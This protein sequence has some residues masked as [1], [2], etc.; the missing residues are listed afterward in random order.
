MRRLIVIL[1]VCWLPVLGI[2]ERAVAGTLVRFQTN[3]GNFDVELYDTAMPQTVAN[4]LQYV[5]AG[6]YAS[7]IIHR[8][9]TYNPGTIQVVQ[10]GGFELEGGTLLPVPQFSP[11][12]LET[13][14]LN[15][16]GTIAMARGNEPDTATSQIFF[17]I[18]NNAPLDGS[19]AVFGEILGPGGLA[20]LDAMG[21][22]PVYDASA[23][24]GPV[25]TELPLL[26]P[27]LDPS[28]LILVQNV[29]VVPEPVSSLL[30][31]AGMLMLVLVCWKRQPLRGG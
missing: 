24:L 19:Y 1:L 15:L 4:F 6:R 10:G 5:N 12:N 14:P 25:F 7:T 21:T 16:R 22:T 17:N 31:S 13:G 18:Q 28:S 30:L 20:V 9:T 8:S 26:Q 27:S 11:I 2:S 29:T 23:Q 3:L